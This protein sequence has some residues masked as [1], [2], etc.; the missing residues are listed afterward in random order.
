MDFEVYVGIVSRLLKIKHWKE[1]SLKFYR[2]VAVPAFLYGIETWTLKKG[3][4][5][6]IQDTEL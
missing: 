6:I 1:T 3:D 5:K 4:W 2:V